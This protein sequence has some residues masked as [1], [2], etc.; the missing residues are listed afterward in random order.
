[1]GEKEREKEREFN[2][3]GFEH[4]KSISALLRERKHAVIRR[5]R[6][7]RELW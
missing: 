2:A 4:P 3:T 5:V 7:R 6:E 1:M